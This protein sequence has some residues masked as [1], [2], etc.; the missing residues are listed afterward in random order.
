MSSMKSLL[1]VSELGKTVMDDVAGE[2][3][4]CLVCLFYR[5]MKYINISYVQPVKETVL[6]QLNNDRQAFL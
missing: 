4:K 5:F 3:Y 6:F 2:R 1:R